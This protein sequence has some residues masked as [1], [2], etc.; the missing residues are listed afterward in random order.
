MKETIL[1]AAIWYKDFEKPVHSPVNINKGVV[2][3][4]YRHGHIIGQFISLTGKRSVT[5]EA[6]EYVQGF[7]TNLN[8]FVDRKE[9]LQIHL[10]N[11]NTSEFN[12][13][14]Y[15]EDLY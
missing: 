5:L 12:D 11:G 10:S 2:L 1:C 13:K 14:L 9:A 6:G 7:L 3:C 4:G 8:R 15:S